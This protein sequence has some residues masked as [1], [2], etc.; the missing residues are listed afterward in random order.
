[1]ADT[2][3]EANKKLFV[4]FFGLCL[5]AIVTI[6]LFVEKNAPLFRQP[7]IKTFLVKKKIKKKTNQTHN[8]KKT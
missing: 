2:E 4:F 3:C 5:F 1:V 6:Q 8:L 7:Q